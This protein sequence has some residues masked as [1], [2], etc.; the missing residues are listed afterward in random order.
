[1]SKQLAVI[2]IHGMGDTQPNYA[3]DL[4]RALAER[5]GNSR[6]SKQI[7]FKP[8][9]YQDTLQ[10][11]QTAIFERSRPYI[12]YMALRKF[13]LFGF[14]D[15]ASLEAGKSNPNS[16]YSQTQ[17]LIMHAFRDAFAAAGDQKI[18]VVLIA[19]SLGC[20]VMSNYLWDA[21]RTRPHAGIWLK[22]PDDVSKGS[23]ED[24]MLRGKTIRRFFTTGCNIPVFVSGHDQIK[25]IPK[26]NPKFEW[27]NYYD[28]DDVLGWPLQPLSADYQQRV[29]DHPINAGGRW[30]E[31]LYKS[32]SPLSHNGYW[33]DSEFL[34]PL[35][36]T[37]GALID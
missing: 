37:I 32:W 19:H 10:A 17:A 27:H 22:Q 5:V 21:T 2:T 7:F 12:D 33:D 36:T 4:H 24:A 16:K 35:S 1:M 20:Q 29:V 11:N 13:V 26:L 3:D 15:A 28:E 34:N 31:Y 18:P 30:F 23:D 8:I 25:P 6:W 9:Y 14:S